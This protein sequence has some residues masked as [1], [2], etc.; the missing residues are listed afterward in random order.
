MKFKNLFAPVVKVGTKIASKTRANAPQ[1][2]FY[3]GIVLMTVGAGYGVY[4]AYKGASEV[5]E[6]YNDG[7]EYID[8]LYSKD[9]KKERFIHGTKNV[10]STGLVVAKQQAVPIVIFAGG[11]VLS[12]KG[13]QKLAARAVMLAGLA[14]ETK[15]ELDGFFGRVSDQYGED[16][17]NKLRYGL[18]QEVTEVEVTDPATGKVTKKKDIVYKET[19][20]ANALYSYILEEGT[21]DPKY[22]SDSA[23]LNKKRLRMVIE[24]ANAIL[25]ERGYIF[26]S[27]VLRMI[28]YKGKMTDREHFTGWI[29]KGLVPDWHG[30]GFVSDGVTDGM[31]R[32]ERVQAFISGTEPNVVVNFNVDGYIV[33]ALNKYNLW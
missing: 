7:K 3:G 4:K 33:D 25:N 32:T 16:E 2:L 21:M 30:D 29:K 23:F 24:Q 22:W 12:C 19:G 6:K 9:H 5:S 1:T 28:G 8:N 20:I 14:A 15:K 31:L 17:A 27:E 10:L 13:Y 26:L 18:Q 11:A